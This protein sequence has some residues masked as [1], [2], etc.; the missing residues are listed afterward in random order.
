MQEAGPL[1]LRL[2][3]EGATYDAIAAELTR[4]GV[5]PPGWRPWVKQ[6]ATNLVRAAERH[7]GS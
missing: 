1:V 5:P 6:T 2:R 3:R 7:L 4:R